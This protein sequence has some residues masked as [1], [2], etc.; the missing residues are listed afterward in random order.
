MRTNIDID[1][2]LMQQAMRSSR[3]RTKRAAVEEG[4]RLLILTRA[5]ATIR[6]LR[7]KIRWDG[8][9]HKSRR[10]RLVE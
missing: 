8:D 4:L 5:Q 2:R 6:R 1:N 3:S 7:G 10:G 9:L